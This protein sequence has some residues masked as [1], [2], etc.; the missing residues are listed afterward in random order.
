MGKSS[1]ERLEE[2]WAALDVGDLETAIELAQDIDPTR[3][4]AW[5]VLAT[6]LTE[7]GDQEGARAAVER[8]AALEEGIDLE[9]VRAALDLS[10]WKLDEARARYER[11]ARDHPE[12]AAFGYLS[13]C[14]ELEDDLERADQL[15]ARANRLDPEAWPAIPRLSEE[16]FEQV[17]DRATERLPDA[18]REALA[19]VQVIVERVPGRE[20]IDP[21]DPAATPPDLLGLF[22]CPSLLDRSHESS[23]ELPPTV[24]LFQRNLERAAQ[25]EEHLVEEI[26]TTLYH[27]LGHALGFDEDGVAD[28]GLE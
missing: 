24:Y 17:L 15:L 4:D 20:L 26:V 16:A 3:R 19:D 11:I 21:S 9:W 1:E 7:A 14:C 18:F 12:A 27:E 8:A 22:V 28:M 23:F 25:D 5:V 13:L 2:A 6:A 10:A